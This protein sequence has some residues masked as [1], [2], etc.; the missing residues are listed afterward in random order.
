VAGNVS[1]PSAALTVSLDTTAPDGQI[2]S[3][4]EGQT[5]NDN[6]FRRTCAGRRDYSIC[7][8]AVD[9]VS[10]YTSGLSTI[11]LELRTGADCL[12]SSGNFTPWA[13]GSPLD[14]TPEV[15]WAQDTNANGLPSGDY[16]ARLTTTDIAGNVTV[17]IVNFSMR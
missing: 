11:T 4:S 14:V 7:G 15:D 3:L 12:D 9:A 5:Y 16:T 13:C 2:T 17:H 10:A 1:T 6:Q 8:T